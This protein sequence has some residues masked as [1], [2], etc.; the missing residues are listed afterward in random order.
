M[1]LSN[2]LKDARFMAWLLSKTETSDRTAFFVLW[3]RYVQ[4]K[5]GNKHVNYFK[6]RDLKNVRGVTKQP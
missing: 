4:Y 3:G 6:K 5:K 2:L 1:L